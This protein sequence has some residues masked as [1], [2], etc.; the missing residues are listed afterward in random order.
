[1]IAHELSAGLHIEDA[2]KAQDLSFALEGAPVFRE[3]AGF[4]IDTTDTAHR[5]IQ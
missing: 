2:D 3:G 1:M 5:R 4:A